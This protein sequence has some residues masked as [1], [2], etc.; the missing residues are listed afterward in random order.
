MMQAKAGRKLKR[1][2]LS[3]REHDGHEETGLL[4]LR[5]TSREKRRKLAASNAIQQH[6]AGGFQ[7]RFHCHRNRAS[8]RSTQL[9][10][11]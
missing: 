9:Q 1:S 8:A 4:Q 6:I 7:C 5:A 2:N 11:G 3:P 10:Q